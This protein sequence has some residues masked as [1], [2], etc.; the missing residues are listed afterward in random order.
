MAP[1]LVTGTLHKGFELYR[2]LEDPLAKSMFMMFLI[3][4]VHPFTDGN[5]RIA[6]IMMNAELVYGHRCRIIIP[7][8]YRE[9][10]L[11][12]LRALTRQG[13]TDPYIRMLNRAQEFTSQVDFNDYEAALTTSRQANAFLDPSEGKLVMPKEGGVA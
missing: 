1:E 11:L 2:A 12:A 7:T 13:N 9:D 10:Y 5:G 4:E 3:A 6:R 8:V